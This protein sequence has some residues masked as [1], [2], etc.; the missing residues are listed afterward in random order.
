M[1]KKTR[2]GGKQM[3]L[4]KQIEELN[5]ALLQSFSN[6]QDQTWGVLFGTNTNRTIMMQTMPM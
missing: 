4:I 2:I 3:D 5:F 1:D 6:K